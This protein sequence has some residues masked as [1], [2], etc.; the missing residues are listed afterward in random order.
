[1][2]RDHVHLPCIP[3]FSAM[4]CLQKKCCRVKVIFSRKNIVTTMKLVDNQIVTSRLRG[5]CFV[6]GFIAKNCLS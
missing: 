4:Y 6:T 1:M 3:F 5:K 2:S